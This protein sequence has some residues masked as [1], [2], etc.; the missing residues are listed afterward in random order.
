[1]EVNHIKTGES[2]S[3]VSGAVYQCLEI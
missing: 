3:L 2:L 1:M